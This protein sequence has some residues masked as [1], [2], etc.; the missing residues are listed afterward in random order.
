MSDEHFLSRWS[1][2]K[3]ASKATPEPQAALQP[4]VEIGSPL[5]PAAIVAPGEPTPPDPPFTNSVSPE[6]RRAF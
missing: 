5:P 3:H 1:R 4:G 6:R 2:R